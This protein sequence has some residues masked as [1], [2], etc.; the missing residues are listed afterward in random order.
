MIHGV[1]VYDPLEK[2]ETVEQFQK[3][4]KD[5]F[6]GA[7]DTLHNRKIIEGYLVLWGEKEKMRKERK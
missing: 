3:F 4:M 5:K 2:I 7:P 1:L 6:V